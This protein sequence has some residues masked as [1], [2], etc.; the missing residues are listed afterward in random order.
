MENPELLDVVVIGAGA[1]GLIAARDLARAGLRV[2]VLEA[3]SRVGGR[4]CTRRPLNAPTVELGPEF[5]HGNSEVLWKLVTEANVKTTESPAVQWVA[6]KQGLQRKDD[7]WDRIASTIEKLDPDHYD[8]LGAWLKAEGQEL[9]AEDRASTREFV[10]GFHAAPADR[11]SSRTLKE[12]Q[13]G[14][15]EEQHRVTNGYDRVPLRLAQEF[16]G[17]G[18]E[19][20]LNAVVSKIQWQAGEV[21]VQTRGELGDGGAVFRART[22]VVTLP[23]GVLKAAPGHVGAVRFEPELEEKRALWDQLEMGIVSRLVLRF[24]P[25]FWQETL[26]PE[27][28]RASHGAEFGFVHAPGAPIPVWWS[29]APEPTLVGWTGGPAARALVGEVHPEVLKIAL[30]SLAELFGCNVA[31]LD[32]ALVESHWH[33][34]ASDPFCRGGYSYSTAGLEDAPARLAEPVDGTLFFAGEATASPAD[35]GTVS[36]AL[37]SGVRVAQEVLKAAVVSERAALL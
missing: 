11:M 35:L 3:R 5:V 14:A 26:A 1:A 15:Q 24:E 34:W 9:S 30:Q 33:D 12:T 20:H 23:L 6:T 27:K 36:G 8:S 21:H 25:H 4:I 17:A 22:A 32:S 10:E 16:H 29:A 31:A 2:V 28:L 7:L 18:G 13:G 19:I 37:E